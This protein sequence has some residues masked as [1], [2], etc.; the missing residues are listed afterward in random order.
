M[1]NCTC[2]SLCVRCAALKLLTESAMQELSVKISSKVGEFIKNGYFLIDNAFP[3]DYA[4]G[5]E[6]EIFTLYNSKLMKSNKVQFLVKNQGKP[7]VITKPGIF[8]ADLYDFNVRSCGK[9]STLRNIYESSASDLANILEQA[10]GLTVSSAINGRVVKVQFNTGK[11]GCFPCHYDNPGRPNR[12][13]LTCAFYLNTGWKKGDGGELVLHPFL[14]D[15]V[16]IA[17][18]FNRLVV[19]RSDTILHSVTPAKVERKCFTIWF[20]SDDVNKDKDVFL[21][22]PSKNLSIDLLEAYFKNEPVQRL[23]ARAVYSEEF[24]ET[25]KACFYEKNSTGLQILQHQHSIRVQSLLSNSGLKR[26][27]NLL[28]NKIGKKIF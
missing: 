14:Q 25:L 8:E 4:K 12:R 16:T 6:S 23:V 3:Q 9:I 15:K 19:F 2:D 17:P 10:L 21:K 27:I 7:L 24:I 11:G 18:R 26:V 28:R 20:D 5:I 1:P 13:I 22:I